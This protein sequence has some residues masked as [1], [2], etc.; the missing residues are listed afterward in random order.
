MAWIVAKIKWI[1]LLSGVLTCT[2]IFAA[3]A[4]QEALR[5][6]F[7]ADLADT[8]P[9]AQIVVRNWGALIALVG[10]MLIHGAYKPSSRALVATVAAVS[11]LVFV[12]LVLTFGRQYL[13]KVGIAIAFDGL[14]IALLIGYLI[15]IQGDK[16][17][18]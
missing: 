18:R 3:I 4:P 1:M 13:G 2:M 15:G 8:G 14:V 16:A 9:L 17:Q 5:S 12:A 10:A 6:M 7:G 11:K